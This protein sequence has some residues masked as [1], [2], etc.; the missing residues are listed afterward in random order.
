MEE[1]FG[2]EANLLDAH[3]TELEDAECF[4]EHVE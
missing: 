3:E 2:E 1:Y 4:E